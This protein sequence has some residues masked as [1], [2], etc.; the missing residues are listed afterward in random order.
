MH[1][2]PHPVGNRGKTR[3]IHI[4]QERF[5]T[6]SDLA[7]NISYEGKRQI[8]ASQLAQYVLDNFLEQARLKLLSEIPQLS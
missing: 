6:L 1:A 4:G 2:K 8:T 3:V 5:E 7:I